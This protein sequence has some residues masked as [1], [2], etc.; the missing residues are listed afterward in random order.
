MSTTPTNASAKLSTPLPY[1]FLFSAIAL[2]IG[3]CSVHQNG[4]ADQKVAPTLGVSDS[5][6]SRGPASVVSTPHFSNPSSEAT[7]QAG[8]RGGG[9]D[10]EG[11]KVRDS[12]NP[13]D[14]IQAEN[15]KK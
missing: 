8:T 12:A 2:L 3:A 15:Q 5:Q 10:R 9:F 6:A 11:A 14:G 7:G 13:T 4:A 1:A